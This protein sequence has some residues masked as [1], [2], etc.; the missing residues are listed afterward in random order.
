MGYPRSILRGSRPAPVEVR[1]LRYFGSSPTDDWSDPEARRPAPRIPLHLQLTW[2]IV[3]A[4]AMGAADRPRGGRANRP[5]GSRAG[6]R[7]HRHGRQLRRIRERGTARGGPRALSAW[8]GH[9]DQGRLRPPRAGCVAAGGETRV[10]EAVR[11]HEPPAFEAGPAGSVAAAPHR[12]EGSAERAVRRNGG[13][14]STTL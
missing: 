6:H 2:P 10:P 7:L 3:L 14:P 4:W 12:P 8:H 9:R 13:D 11:A 1:S 5:A